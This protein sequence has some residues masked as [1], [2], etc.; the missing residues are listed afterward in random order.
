MLFVSFIANKSQVKDHIVPL[1]HKLCNKDKTVKY[2]RCHNAGKNLKLK[3]ESDCLNLGVKFKFTAPNMPH[4]NEIVE[5]KFANFYGRGRALLNK[6]RFNRAMRKGLWAKAACIA[7]M[8]DSIS[9]KPGETKCPQE[10]LY[11]DVPK[12]ARYLQTFGEVGVV[13][14]AAAIQSKLE[15]K[16]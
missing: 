6:A 8:L 4:Q 7:T 1:I 10:L 2:V 14:S 5:Q 13:K 11:G 9:V 3:Q 15:N 12:W 16:G